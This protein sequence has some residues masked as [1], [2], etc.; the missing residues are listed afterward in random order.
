VP[1]FVHN[2]SNVPRNDA[3][4]ASGPEPGHLE[5]RTIA[6]VWSTIDSKLTSPDGTPRPSSTYTSSTRTALL[7][8]TSDTELGRFLYVSLNHHATVMGSRLATVY[9]TD[10]Q[11]CP[12][13][14]QELV[15]CDLDNTIWEGEIGEGKVR[16][17]P[18][19]RR[20]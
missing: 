17:S 3:S 14:D 12:S 10:R 5:T 9:R 16:T 19:V 6:S 15:V 8:E 13:P 18:T 1:I 11:P 4:S 20:P 7:A 2:A